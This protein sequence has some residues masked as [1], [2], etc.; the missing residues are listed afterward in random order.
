MSYYVRS[1]TLTQEGVVVYADKHLPGS[2]TETKYIIDTKVVGD[3]YNLAFDME[4]L[5]L[6]KFL[7]TMVVPTLET[8]R[9]QALAAHDENENYHV[10]I[11]T[12]VDL[13]NAITILD[14]TF[15]PPTINTRCGWQ[16]DL[17]ESIIINYNKYVIQ[18][19]RNAQNLKDYFK[20]VKSL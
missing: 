1:A 20:Y 8:R 7:D 12:K 5:K 2:I 13:M 14:K 6:Y 17:L 19:C 4:Q 10:D 18:T 16:R 9:I 3:W 15:T 11:D